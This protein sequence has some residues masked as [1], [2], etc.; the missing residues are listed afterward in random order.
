V[1]ESLRHL[2]LEAQAESTE[3][4]RKAVELRKTSKELFESA[5]AASQGASSATASWTAVVG[6]TRVTKGVTGVTGA[7]GKGRVGE[8]ARSLD[9]RARAQW[10]KAEEL[11]RRARQVSGWGGGCAGGL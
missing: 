8:D 7:K 5:K 4:G 1:R 3:E 11:M 6:S 10:G 9:Q 2:S